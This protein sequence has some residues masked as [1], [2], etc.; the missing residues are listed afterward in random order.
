MAELEE[1]EA[2]GTF[3]TS[4]L[5][6]PVVYKLMPSMSCKDRNLKC[7]RIPPSAPPK[8][9]R[10][11][12]FLPSIPETPSLLIPAGLLWPRAATLSARRGRDPDRAPPPPPHGCQHLL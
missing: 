12:S 8:P 2:D 10:H 11:L 3:F 1:R 9:S 6:G 5:G 4:S 7:G